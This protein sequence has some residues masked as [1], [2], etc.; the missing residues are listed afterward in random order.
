MYSTDEKPCD[1]SNILYIFWNVFF[2]NIIVYR[3]VNPV[4]LI[5]H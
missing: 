4:H 3:N 5:V 1:I 2:N